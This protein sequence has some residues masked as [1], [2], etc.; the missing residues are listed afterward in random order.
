MTADAL[1]AAKL[2]LQ[3]GTPPTLLDTAM[4]RAICEAYVDAA[5]AL[6]LLPGRDNPRSPQDVMD[7]VAR[8][9]DAQIECRDGDELIA[10]LRVRLNDAESRCREEV[11]KEREAA[12]QRVLALT[13]VVNPEWIADA[14]RTGW[15]P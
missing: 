5:D 12:A 2:V 10:K 6:A 15:T 3:S 4:I 9:E 1:W 14:I 11:L 7:V 13:G 8:L